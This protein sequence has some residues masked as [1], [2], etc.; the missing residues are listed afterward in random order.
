M[1]RLRPTL[2]VVLASTLLALGS[3]P[4]Y[5]DMPPKVH[6]TSVNLSLVANSNGWNYTQPSGKNPTI[7]VR[8]TDNVYI[9]FTA[10]DALQ[11]RF[12][13]NVTR[14]GLPPCSGADL[15][16][17]VFNST[18]PTTYGWASGVLSPGTYNYYDTNSL[19]TTNGTLLVQPGPYPANVAFW[20][21]ATTNGWN[22]SKPS[23]VN[24]TITVYDGQTVT[25]HLNTT[26][27]PGTQH[28]FYLDVDKN[29]VP[30]CSTQD[31]CSGSFDRTVNVGVFWIGGSVPDGTYHYYDSYYPVVSN[32]TF[33]VKRYTPS[34]DYSVSASPSSLTIRQGASRTSTITVTSLNNYTGTVS[35]TAIPTGVTATLNPTSVSLS[36]NGIAISTVNVTASSSVSP[37]NYQVMITASNGTTQRSTP[38]NVQVTAADFTLR[39]NNNMLN[40]VQGSSSTAT[41][42][43]TSENGFSGKVSL[44]DQVSPNGPTVSQNPPAVNI[45]PGGSQTSNIT[46]STTPTTHPGSYTI[47]LTANSTGTNGPLTHTTTITVNVSQLPVSLPFNNPLIS[48]FLFGVLAGI[49][50]AVSILIVAVK[51]RSEAKKSQAFKALTDKTSQ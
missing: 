35:L 39:T 42:T 45:A 13:V 36:K 40:I 47:T 24:P 1:G 33:I 51:Y 23:G 9:S 43:I 4:F 29:G 49:I 31:M 28:Q 48:T 8:A 50:V 7:T 11:H 15:C 18:T 34:P 37:G 38:V 41:I 17:P 2:F 30:D 10:S 12:F 21:T 6:A 20:L 44:K 32:G 25:I 5:Q 26:D 22:Y 19:A 27:P 14:S 46:I 16:S 3:Y